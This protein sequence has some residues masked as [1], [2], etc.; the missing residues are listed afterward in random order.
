M[1][2]PWRVT[3][4]ALMWLLVCGV[5]VSGLA[6]V[7]ALWVVGMG[8]A[9][10][11]RSWARAA[12]PVVEPSRPSGSSEDSKRA[13]AAPPLEA[14]RSGQAPPDGE[15]QTPPTVLAEGPHPENDEHDAATGCPAASPSTPSQ[16]QNRRDG[17]GG[18][19]GPPANGGAGHVASADGQSSPLAIMSANDV[20]RLL[21]VDAGVVGQAMKS[22]SFPGNEL[23]GRWMCN[24]ESLVRWLDGHWS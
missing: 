20:A 21:G 10:V 5:F 7:L 2:S 6:N 13:S 14:T 12:A 11:A 17:G 15:S 8:L 9:V 4:A 24:R 22:G 23:G 18:G 19:V 3:A 16:G 1:H